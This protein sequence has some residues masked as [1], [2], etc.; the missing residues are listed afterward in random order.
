MLAFD[1][2]I[3]AVIGCR[4]E[5]TKSR[6]SV[7]LPTGGLV[8]RLRRNGQ[9]ETKHREQIDLATQLDSNKQKRKKKLL[10]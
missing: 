1:G 5:V 7:T 6:P 3:V 10:S 2:S 4:S 9:L 8:T